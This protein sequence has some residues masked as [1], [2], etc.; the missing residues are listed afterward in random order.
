MNEPRRASVVVITGAS[1]GVGRAIALRFAR[2]G[3]R[4]AIIGRSAVGLQS[5]GQEIRSLG[6][7]A[8]EFAL[9]V[10]EAAAVQQAADEVA[11][12]WGG[13]DV[14]VNNA[15]VTMFAPVWRMSA[16]EFQRITEVTYLGYVYGTMAAL[17]HMRSRNKGVIIQIGSALSYRAIPLQS[18]YCGAKSAVRAFTDALRS[19]L[20]HEDSGIRLTM[21]QLPAVNTPQFDWARNVFSRRPQPLAPIFQPE[22]IAEIVFHASPHPPREIW[23]GLPTLKLIAGAMVGPGLLD[24]YLARKAFDGQLSG[25]SEPPGRQ[26]NLFEPSEQPHAVRGRFSRSA[27]PNVGGFDPFW[28]RCAIVACLVAA[29]F[30]AIGLGVWLGFRSA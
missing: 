16:A 10:S 17:R 5:T 4:I 14:W 27:R 26:D 2:S 25:D 20:L 13:I 19:E 22:A 1:A 24:R 12:S 15:M 11:E 3:A 29:G 30:L 7:E 18:A 23:I 21:A 28:L 9:D 6:G 8:M